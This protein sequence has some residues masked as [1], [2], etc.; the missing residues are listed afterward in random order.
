MGQMLLALEFQIGPTYEMV[1]AGDPAHESTQ[2]ALREV[3]RRFLPNKVL[4][5][6]DGKGGKPPA[7]LKD[8]LDGKSA[9]G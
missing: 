4:A 3:R 1:L 2:A 9:A 5:G 7:L 6:V 8:L